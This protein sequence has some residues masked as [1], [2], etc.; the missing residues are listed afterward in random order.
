MPRAL[1]IPLVVYTLALGLA[2]PAA[3][4]TTRDPGGA[5]AIE[6]LRD[7]DMR[8]L[9]VHAAPVEAPD[10]PFAGPDGAETTLAA[11]NGKVRL[12]NFWATWCAP[13][14]E[15]MPA[16]AALRAGMGGEDFDVLLVATGRNDPAAIARF[17]AEEGIEGIA[18]GLDPK[19]ALARAAGAPG[20]PVTLVLDRDGREVAR[21]IG[22][23]DWNGESARAIVGALIAR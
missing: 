22:G 2:S 15:E 10:T 9:V 1:A 14:R 21:L 23:A 13:C 17:F 11:S 7:G 18:T 12:V 19:G 16:L 20:L 6:A 4:D 8:K 3:A 5:A